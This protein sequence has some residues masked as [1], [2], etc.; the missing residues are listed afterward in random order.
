[1]HKTLFNLAK[2]NIKN[3]KKHYTIVA[4]I[5]FIVA[6]IMFSY[7]LI[8][9]NI[10]EIVR[11]YNMKTY[12]N[13]YASIQNI[14]EDTKQSIETYTN[15]YFKD[16]IQYGYVKNQGSYKNYLI[17]HI[18]ESIYDLCKI[19]IISGR[20]IKN[21]NE[22]LVS[23]T[24]V[25]KEKVKIN[26]SI[27]I[28]GS[29]YIIVGITHTNN[30]GLPEVY[31]NIDDAYL[32]RDYYANMK[33]GYDDG[34]LSY[35][36][37]N[38]EYITIKLDYVFNE[39]GY[40]QNEINMKIDDS[41]EIL[42]SFFVV[43]VISMFILFALTSASLK[44]RKKEMALLRGI[45]MTTSQ[46][47]I[48]IL[49]ENIITLFLSIICGYL[50]G[51]LLSLGF[52][53][54]Q[55]TIYHI[56]IYKFNVQI[57]IAAVIL[58]ICCVFLSAIIPI[59]SSS[60]SALTGSF[61][62][63][64]FKYIQVRYKKLK[65][66]TLSYL[67]SRELKVDKKI[68]ICYFIF[69]TVISMY[70]LVCFYD[71]H[72]IN[73]SNENISQKYVSVS[74]QNQK[75]IDEFINQFSNDTFNYQKGYS[76]VDMLLQYAGLKSRGTM[77]IGL[78]ENNKFDIVGQLQGKIPTKSHEILVTQNIR[79]I[80]L[81]I[82]D[83]PDI[84]QNRDDSNGDLPIKIN[85]KEYQVTGGAL[86][87]NN[88]YES[89]D[90]KADEAHIGDSLYINNEEYKITAILIE[91]D[92]DD[93]PLSRIFMCQDDFDLLVNQEDTY[94]NSRHYL[95]N[96]EIN[97]ALKFL[98]GKNNGGNGTWYNNNIGYGDVDYDGYTFY[99][100]IEYL[101]IVIAVGIVMMLFLNYS[102]MENNY[103][104]YQ[105]YHI[106]G[107]SYQEIKIKQ[108]WKSIHMFF[109]TII[110]VILYCLIL[111][112]FSIDHYIPFLQILGLLVIIFIVYFIIYNVPLYLVLNNHKNEELRNGD[113]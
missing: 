98:K 18:D 5:T 55:S 82:E 31:T 39:Y 32:S 48:M 27:N 24:Y 51:I 3:Y 97:Y 79:N 53:Y 26:D 80:I 91:E 72:P 7:L 75:I 50:L 35:Y 58:F 95:E 67:A 4:I 34:T 42:S 59:I 92:T 103:Q 54:Y 12:G 19:D 112:I 74:T 56:F 63:Q 87:E 73:T 107:L 46:L 85:G 17:G 71:G 57:M 25:K 109:M 44:K 49:Y 90:I 81:S 88:K 96:N 30:E 61:D 52:V 14:E 16:E 64:K 84:F 106:L 111:I 76:D 41:L 105:M 86:D 33:L 36:D 83:Y 8:N 29:D 89:F 108:M 70:G 65:K 20:K 23:D 68:N 69:I 6:V 37:E 93:F 77:D 99:I 10:N 102:N 47:I 28:N 78:L 9:E 43:I 1:M 45:G 62:S 113:E 110:P 2:R 94:L 15:L 100:Q 60:K 40:D 13:W 101:F 11:N 22:I 21:D 38:D 104:D 66:Q